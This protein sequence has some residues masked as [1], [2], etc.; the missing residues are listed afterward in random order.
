MKNRI[1]KIVFLFIT[2]FWY[3]TFYV[4]SYIFNKKTHPN[5]Y[6]FYRK[7][8]NGFENEEVFLMIFIILSLFLSIILLIIYKQ[9][10]KNNNALYYIIFQFLFHI[11]L[12]LTAIYDYNTVTKYIDY[13]IRPYVACNFHL[14]FANLFISFA[15]FLIIIGI[16]KFINWRITTKK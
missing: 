11:S 16:D 10:N 2:L 6:Q 4:F 14:Y 5:Q 8:L 13:N 1:L 3:W 7:S 9:K 15:I 12:V